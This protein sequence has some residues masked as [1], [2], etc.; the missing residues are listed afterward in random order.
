MTYFFQ[1]CLQ[2][3]AEVDRDL[4]QVKQMAHLCSRGLAVHHSGILPLLK[5]VVEMLFQGGYI[6]V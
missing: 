2:R 3:L 5:E 6:K 1:K 4:P